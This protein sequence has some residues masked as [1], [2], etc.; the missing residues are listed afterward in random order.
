MSLTYHPSKTETE[1]QESIA[2]V[3][4]KMNEMCLWTFHTNAVCNVPLFCA[5][6]MCNSRGPKCLLMIIVVLPFK[7]FPLLN[8]VSLWS[9]AFS[10][11]TSVVITLIYFTVNW[12]YFYLFVFNFTFISVIY[13]KNKSKSDVDYTKTDTI[14]IKIIFYLDEN[15][16]H[17]KLTWNSF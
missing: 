8:D 9:V 1:W 17:G 3:H 10:H 12:I 15:V 2:S 16:V 5:M 7:S 13:Y 4:E 11:I 14:I 6:F